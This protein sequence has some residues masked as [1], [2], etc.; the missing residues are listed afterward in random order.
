MLGYC[1]LD[2]KEKIVHVGA[3]YQRNR[4]LKVTGIKPQ[5]TAWKLD[6]QYYQTKLQPSQTYC[7]MKRN[8]YVEMS[9]LCHYNSFVILNHEIARIR[10][11]RRYNRRSCRGREIG[12]CCKHSPHFAK[13]CK[14]IIP[15][16]IVIVSHALISLLSGYVQRLWWYNT[17]NSHDKNTGLWTVMILMAKSFLKH[18]PRIMQ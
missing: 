17:V 7:L 16:K 11:S 10:C 6:R 18:A 5:I 13:S 3:K 9:F 8:G 2:P 14:C 1:Q 15:N 12:Y 4:D